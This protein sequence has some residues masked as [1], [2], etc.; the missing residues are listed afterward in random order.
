M[1]GSLHR[2]IETQA[3]WVA[4]VFTGEVKLPSAQ[5]MDAEVLEWES[6]IGEEIYNPMRVNNLQYIQ[7][8]KDLIN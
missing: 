8:I 3:Q 2:I 1:Q 7:T 6:N 5:E 4:K